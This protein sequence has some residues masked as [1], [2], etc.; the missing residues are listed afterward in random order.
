MSDSYSTYAD[1]ELKIYFDE[2]CVTSGSAR[3][4]RMD[5]VP[6]RSPSHRDLEIDRLAG[7]GMEVEE[8][9]EDGP[10]DV[11]AML[12][13][14]ADRGKPVSHFYAAAALATE[15]EL[16]SGRPASVIVCAG[17]CQA[18]GALPLLDRAAEVWEARLDKKL[19][20]FDIAVRSCMDRC[21]Q[22]AVCEVRGPGGAVV[23]TESTPDKLAE[24]LAAVMA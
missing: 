13:L 14:A 2:R 11:E 24:A 21:D 22:A 9:G 20:L 4:R 23:I 5:K 19:P 1:E 10:I 12:Q 16:A 18:W 17:K 8:L 15:V 6:T 7:L 3:V